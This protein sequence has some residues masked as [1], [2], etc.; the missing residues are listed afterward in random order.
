MFIEFEMLK[1]LKRKPIFENAGVKRVEELAKKN[2][3][4]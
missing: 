1:N 3:K 4:I 2:C